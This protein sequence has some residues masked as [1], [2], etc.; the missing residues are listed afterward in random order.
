MKSQERLTQLKGSRPVSSWERQA[1]IARGNLD[2]ALKDGK[3]GDENMRKLCR[4][5]NARAD[6][7]L[8][9]TG[10]PYQVATF[11]TDQDLAEQ[12]CAH[13][14]DEAA[15]WTLTAITR[16]SDNL[17]RAVVMTMPII[18]QPP[19]STMMFYIQLEVLTG[20][21]GPFSREAIKR[22]GWGKRQQV[23]LDDDVVESLCAGGIG[24]YALAHEP[25]YLQ[26]A[27]PL[28]DKTLAAL[29]TNDVAERMG[30]YTVPLTPPEQRLLT[31]YRA[32]P[33]DDRERLLAIADALKGF[34]G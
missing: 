24:T 25:G 11:N 21:I 5:E 14:T 23:T 16:K 8:F 28:D 19:E 13:H 18:T 12:I 27:V 20:P 15:R 31:T 34:S 32:M 26:A 30:G 3:I 29:A 6:W 1:G 7:I 10:A 4:L 17:P 2:R 22:D 33:T 9:G